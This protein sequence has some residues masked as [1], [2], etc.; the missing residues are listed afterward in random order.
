LVVQHRWSIRIDDAYQQNKGIRVAKFTSKDVARLAGVSQ[1]TVSYVMNGNRPISEATRKRVLDAI[2]ALTYQ[3]NAGARALASQ[4]TRVV[5]LMVVPAHGPGLDGVPDAGALPF[6]E[7]IASSAR[8]HDHDVLLVTA[9]EGSA[10]L[11][12]LAERSLCDAIVLMDIETRDDRVPVAASLSVPVILIGVP[13]DPAGLSCVDLDHKLAARMAVE[14]LATTGH[15]R[16]VFMGYPAE[17]VERDVNYVR[18]FLDAACETADKHGLPYELISPVEPRRDSAQA[19]VDRAL[20]G[21]AEG[22]LGIVVPNSS[23]LQLILNALRVRGVVPGRDVSLVALCTDVV[24]EQADP[25]LT[26]LSIEPRDVSLR[27]METLFRL[28]EPSSAGAPPAVD[29]VPPRLTTRE[30]VMPSPSSRRNR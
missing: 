22:R 27:A 17:V 7:T 25:P 30:S 5:G 21:G 11:R 20:A 23:A 3:P 10:G 29:L 9:D 24:A 6:I 16:L 14:E 26:N 12:R 1:S 2:E 13:E 8:E 4:R 28:L 19:A 15:D 18:R